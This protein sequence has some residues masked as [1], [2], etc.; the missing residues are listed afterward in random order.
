MNIER[1]SFIKFQT[2]KLTARVANVC[3]MI[4]DV[5]LSSIILANFNVFCFDLT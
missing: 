2:F 3:I 1:G 4:Y 5:N